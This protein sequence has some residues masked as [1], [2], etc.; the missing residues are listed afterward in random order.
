MGTD[1]ETTN[2]TKP[3]GPPLPCGTT[4]THPVAVWASALTRPA[5]LGLPRPATTVA[6]V[7]IHLKGTLGQEPGAKD[8]HH[9][10]E[11]RRTKK[12]VEL[13][14]PTLPLLVGI[15]TEKA[16]PERGFPSVVPPE[17]ILWK[18]TGVRQAK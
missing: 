12:M 4:S 13:L 14:A 8:R 10:Q 9:S 1:R 5:M 2:Q 17:P 6:W 15:W 18:G 7:A 16:P 3:G 11:T